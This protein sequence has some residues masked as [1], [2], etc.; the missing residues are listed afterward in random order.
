MPLLDWNITAGFSPM[1]TSRFSRCKRNRAQLCRHK[2]TAASSR[3]PLQKHSVWAQVRRVS[4]KFCPLTL[5]Q[6]SCEVEINKQLKL[7]GVWRISEVPWIWT[8]VPPVMA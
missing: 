3:R 5:V 6:L 7:I 2:K 1:F 8:E 4:T